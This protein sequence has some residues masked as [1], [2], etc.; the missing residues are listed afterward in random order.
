MPAATEAQLLVLARRHQQQL[1]TIR[2]RTTVAIGRLW[3]TFALDPSDSTLAGWLAASVPVVESAMQATAQAS[4]AY[5]P[6]YVAAAT[7]TAPVRS[8]LDV[9]D[10][11]R[12][13]GVD[14]ADV[15]RRPFVT[16]RTALANGESLT[17]A[18]EI[19][20]ARATQIA[21]TDPML[22]AR[23][24]SSE[25]MRLE[26]KVV[27]FRRVPDSRACAFCRLAATQRYRDVD[28]MPMHSSCGCSV[29][30]IIGDKD[31]GQVIER[32]QLRQL[33]ADGV[34]DEISLRRYI[35]STDEVVAEYE[36]KAKHWR[37]QARTTT[38]QAAETRYAKRADEWQ[39]KARERAADVEQARAR[40]KAIRSGRLD[41]LTAVHEHGEL[42]P[43]L[44][45]AGV[46]FTAV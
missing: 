35:S 18:R 1:L 36:A 29:A 19:A 27:G 12:P 23:A 22:S 41:R 3:A 38:D 30:P 13:R 42:G 6:S 20:G 7:D 32:E 40:L 43:V 9:A 4:L 44:Y 16:M 34:I 31:P 15:L 17:R 14:T 10:F 45:P 26:P 28:L 11:L 25:A 24:A 33:K 2:E 21:S 46:E 5:V 8:T 37:E 39:R